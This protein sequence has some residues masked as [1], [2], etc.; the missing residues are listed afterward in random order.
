MLLFQFI[1][2]LLAAICLSRIVNRFI[3]VLSVT[4]VQIALG[5]L[6]T[7]LPLSCEFEWE[8]HLFFVL[9]VAPLVFSTSMK[10]DKETMWSQ[11]KTILSMSIALVLITIVSVGYLL[12]FLVPTIPLAAAFA[13]IAA[14]GLTDD[15]AVSAV[16]KRI[17]V[18]PKIQTILKGESIVN[19]ASGIVVF[20]FALVAMITGSF[21]IVHAT[22]RFFV[23]AVG[24]IA[25]GLLLCWL[26]YVLVRW[27]RSLGM[28]NVTLHLLL[29]ILTPFL[30]YIVAE[31]LHV[32]GI[33]AI[34]AAGITHSFNRDKLNPDKVNF[35]I[36]SDSVWSM[37]TYTLEGLVFVIMGTQLPRIL[38]SISQN[39]F[40]ISSW[41]IVSYI[42]L[43]NLLFLILRFLWTVVMIRKKSYHDP[44]RPVRRFRAGI[45]FS[46]SGAR[47]AVT[48]ASVMS[49]PFFLSNGEAFPERDLIILIAAGDIVVSLLLTSF[50]LPLCVE[51][52]VKAD[53]SS[54][55]KAYLE[56]LHT[57]ISE[58]NR[59]ATPENKIATTII[60]TNYY[61]RST[62]L[63][64][65]LNTQHIDYEEER[66]WKIAICTWEKENLSSMVEQGE[67]DEESA[68]HYCDMLDAEMDRL[69]KI[70]L[71][72]RDINKRLAHHIHHIRGRKQQIE[73]HAKV[74]KVMELNTRFVLEKLREL[75]QLDNHPVS[76]KMIA[77]YEFKLSLYQRDFRHSKP[78][79][80]MLLSVASHGFQIERDNIQLMFE[81]GRISR[82]TAKELRHNISLLE[83]QLKKDHF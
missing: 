68:H 8:P 37:L 18:P 70:R 5:A 3:P 21:S 7:L 45:I 83:V 76:R 42:L 30:I 28:E 81:A 47:G 4:I 64:R 80:E 22:G 56:V 14:L 58:L 53:K 39:T 38:R 32:S 48:L 10:A 61:N 24:G 13:L 16:G 31:A 74:F 65:Q 9:F 52:K 6:I 27:I 41:D 54:E 36:A 67:A 51:K 60:T 49:I 25:T 1:L 19:E 15:V 43:L 29:G 46:L 71:A 79:D 62:E 69:L 40:S 11:R 82:E 12:N 73:E 23:V 63:Q 34:F 20:Q 55:N 50:I 77:E 17:N 44:A 2:I 75:N 59:S 33:L 78:D 26:K 66:K 57:V 72:F 35:N